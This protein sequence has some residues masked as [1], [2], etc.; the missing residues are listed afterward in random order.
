M[1]WA[2]GGLCKQAPS[3]APGWA[4]HRA[5]GRAAC[6]AATDPAG[7]L[8]PQALGTTVDLPLPHPVRGEPRG[9]RSTE[10]WEEL[11]LRTGQ[12]GKGFSL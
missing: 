8:G 2:R 4:Q 12:G 7:R 10:Q 1:S 9:P 3:P 11:S 6:S 5:A